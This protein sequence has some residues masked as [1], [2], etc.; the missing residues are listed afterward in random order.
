MHA[1]IAGKIRKA[2][3]EH[4]TRSAVKQLLDKIAADEE[5]FPGKQYGGVRGRKRVL[6]GAKAHSLCR[7]AKAVKR[8]VDVVTYPLLCASAPKAVAN[9]ETGAAVN[10][11]AVY[12]CIKGRLL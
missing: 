2:N 8:S 5:W 6:T 7:S 12:Q 11:H 3:G 4:P 9:P 10:K 1:F